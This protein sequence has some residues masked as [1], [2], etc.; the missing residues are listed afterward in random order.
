MFEESKYCS[1]VVKKH[2]NKELVTAKGDNENFQNSNKCWICDNDYINIK[3]KISDHCHMTG[4]YRG[5]AYRNCNHKIPIVFHNVKKY[6]SHLLMHNLGKFNLKTS[7]IPNELERYTSL[8]INDKLSFVDNFQFL[9]F[10]LDRL[11]KNLKKM[12]LSI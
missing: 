4:K 10:S 7:I 11:V 9:R 3:V 1:D 6:D 5:S 2:F 12:I 8:T